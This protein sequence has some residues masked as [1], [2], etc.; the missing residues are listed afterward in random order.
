MEN[1]SRNK[2]KIIIHKDLFSKI[3]KNYDVKIIEIEDGDDYVKANGI[4]SYK[5]RS[6]CSGGEIYAGIYENPELKLISVFH[7]LGHIVF[8]HTDFGT[9]DK[10]NYDY[11]NQFRYAHRNRSVPIE[12]ACT[13]YGIQ[14]ALQKYGITFSNYAL[15]W[16]YDC[17]FSYM[18]RDSRIE[19]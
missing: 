10:R 15:K 8:N 7:E 13:Q 1:S 3:E 18:N 4:D 17:A 2:V 9:K 19:N 12:L 6:S 5:E 14:I 16:I 11:Y